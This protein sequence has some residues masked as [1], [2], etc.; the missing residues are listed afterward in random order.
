MAP[1]DK[2]F[3]GNENGN[4]ARNFL[5]QFLQSHEG[6]TTILGLE[7]HSTSLQ[8]G[9]DFVFGDNGQKGYAKNWPNCLGTHCNCSSN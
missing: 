1:E 4:S 3:D 8:C 9:M 7:K 6:T 2:E 5:L